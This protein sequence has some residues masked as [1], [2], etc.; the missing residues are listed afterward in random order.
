MNKKKYKSGSTLKI[1]EY[2]KKLVDKIIKAKMEYRTN[3]SISQ[4]L[5]LAEGTV[6]YIVAKYKGDYPD[7]DE[8]KIRKE[9]NKKNKTTYNIPKGE[10][11]C[12][13]TAPISPLTNAKQHFEGQYTVNGSYYILNGRKL[14]QGQFITAYLDTLRRQQ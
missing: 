5:K 9:V 4:E 13:I 6:T 12:P 10:L 2:P 14:L 7:Y 8:A 3:I 1:R 11:I